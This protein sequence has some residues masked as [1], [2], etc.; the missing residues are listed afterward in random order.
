M[1]LLALTRRIKLMI[2]SF[3]QHEDPWEGSSHSGEENP[4]ENFKAADVNLTKLHLRTRLRAEVVPMLICCRTSGLD[5]N[6]YVSIYNDLVIV[7]VFRLSSVCVRASDMGTLLFS[8]FLFHSS[9]RLLS[10]S[11]DVS[12]RSNPHCFFF[13]SNVFKTSNR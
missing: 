3:L 5:I 4:L 6:I 8:S 13:F 7:F 11:A 10:S 1:L 9:T 2:A 12:I